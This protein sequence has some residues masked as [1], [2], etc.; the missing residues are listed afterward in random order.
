MAALHFDFH[1]P[2]TWL[3]LGIGLV[4]LLFGLLFKTLGAVPRHR[5]IV[6]R[7]VGESAAGAVT[8]L[9]A[10]AEICLGLWMVSGYWLVPCVAAQTLLIVA[11]NGCELRYARDLLLSP[12]G[13]VCA[14]LL[15]LGLVR[16]DEFV[17]LAGG[18]GR[19]ARSFRFHQAIVHLPLGPFLGVTARS[20]REPDRDDLTQ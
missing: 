4:W 1:A 13:M 10:L 9:V 2:L 7:V 16:R 11:M 5:Q 17:E 15:F 8:Q 19:D 6:A 14:N 12:V 18:I 3:R 20:R